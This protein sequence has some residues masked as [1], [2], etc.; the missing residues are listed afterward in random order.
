MST[1]NKFEEY[2]LF[3]EDTARF[4]DRRQTVT[5][6]YVA[7]NTILLSAVALVMTNRTLTH[8]LLA[9]TAFAVLAGGIAVCF[10]WRQLIDKYH[11][12]NSV[13]GTRNVLK[14]VRHIHNNVF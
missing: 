13:S 3:I 1:V 6:V 9:L 2:K 12:M 7:V 11:R 4:T 10:F 5:N 14:H 8:W